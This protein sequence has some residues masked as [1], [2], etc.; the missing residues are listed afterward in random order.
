MPT[1]RDPPTRYS[2]ESEEKSGDVPSDRSE[3]SSSKHRGRPTSVLASRVD[4]QKQQHD[5]VSDDEDLSQDVKVLKHE[6]EEMKGLLTE[7]S[8]MLRSSLQ[9]KSASTGHAMT[10]KQTQRTV[11]FTE[12]DERNEDTEEEEYLR[13]GFQSRQVDRGDPVWSYEDPRIPTKEEYKEPSQFFSDDTPLAERVDEAKRGVRKVLP[14]KSL[15]FG[16]APTVPKDQWPL[17]DVT[18]KWHTLAIDILRLYTSLSLGKITDEDYL[19][20]TVAL[21]EQSARESRLEL[22]QLALAAQTTPELAS[23]YR[24]LKQQNEAYDKDLMAMALTLSQMKKK[25]DFTST[26]TPSSSSSF[27]NRK[28]YNNN[29]ERGQYNNSYKERKNTYSSD[30][31]QHSSRR[32]PRRFSSPTKKDDS[33]ADSGQQ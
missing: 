31:R 11:K 22:L 8:S 30:A 27:R 7:F 15:H 6:M 25:R 2:S 13:N 29:R 19:Q 12:E 23:T 14:P 9:E 18:Y 20:W 5:A 3:S 26:G 1:L 10:L 21:A 24:K 17:R 28:N 16:K 33:F 32:S 4:L